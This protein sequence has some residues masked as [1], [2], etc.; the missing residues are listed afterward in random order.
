M[1]QR[2]K[3]T[4]IRTRLEGC[5]P[6]MRSTKTQRDV[7]YKINLESRWLLTQLPL[8]VTAKTTSACYFYNKDN[9]SATSKSSTKRWNFLIQVEKA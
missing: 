7:Y 5:N 4:V 6:L 1:F 9:Q 8:K 3:I 2:V